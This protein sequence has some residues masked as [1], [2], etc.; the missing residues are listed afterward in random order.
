M[1]SQCDDKATFEWCIFLNIGMRSIQQ[2]PDVHS[3]VIQCWASVAVFLGP[4]CILHRDKAEGL[5]VASLH[6]DSD[7]GKQ[8]GYFSWAGQLA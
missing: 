7:K 5:Q 6:R 3:M 4:A 2:T 8:A 1:W